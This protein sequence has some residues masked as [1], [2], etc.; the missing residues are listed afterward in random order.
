[1]KGLRE[2]ARRFA[3]CWNLFPCPLCGHG[4]GGGA[5][6]FCSDCAAGL[7]PM[8]GPACP[9]CGGPLDTIFG[10]CSRCQWQEPRPWLRAVALYEYQGTAQEAITRFK[11]RGAPFFVRA[12][13]EP[14][15][16]AVRRTGEPVDVLVPVPL[17]WSRFWQRGYNQS[18]LLARHCAAELGVPWCRALKRVRPTPHQLSL[19]RRE[20]LAN[21][22]GAF[23]TVRKEAV[24]GRNVWLVDDVLTTGATLS[25][26]AQ[27]L[28]RSGAR[29]IRVL[30][31]ARA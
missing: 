14:A 13:A 24:R 3:G 25:E 22:K 31:I 4:D 17:H 1:M 23:K 18:E 27:T 12:L 7:T 2:A 11:F 19:S 26:C 30:V 21:L 5:N 9:G 15:A 10:R 29:T 28:L 6:L 20:R 8:T 16:E